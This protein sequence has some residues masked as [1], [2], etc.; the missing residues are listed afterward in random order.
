MHG[1]RQVRHRHFGASSQRLPATGRRQNA[2]CESRHDRRSPGRECP[3]RACRLGRSA[4]AHAGCRRSRPARPGPADEPRQSQTAGQRCIVESG[5]PTRLGPGRSERPARS[6]HH[7]DLCVRHAGATECVRQPRV[8]AL[9]TEHE[10]VLLL[11]PTESQLVDEGVGQDAGR[12]AWTVLSQYVQGGSSLRSSTRS[13]SAP[14][15]SS[16]AYH[17]GCP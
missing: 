6:R 17:C 1:L 4:G 11:L 13:A 8:Q 5:T 7:G 16:W 3:A 10:A 9:P 2:F 14:S 15:C 12:S